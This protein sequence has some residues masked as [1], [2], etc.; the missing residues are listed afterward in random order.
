MKTGEGKTIT[1]IAPVYLNALSG[2]GAIVSTV[3]EYLAQRDAEEMGQVFTFLGLS[4]GI[5]RAQMDPSLKRE[6]YA[7]DITYSIHSELGFDYL[8]DN[9][10]SKHWR[11]SAKRLAFLLNWRSWFYI[12]WWS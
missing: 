11:K 4:V 8:R 5:N 9:M 1:S 3:N 10:A 6:A 7:C 12:N 2:K